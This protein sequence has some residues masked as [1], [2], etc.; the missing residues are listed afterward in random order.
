MGVVELV[1]CKSIGL[2]RLRIQ[3]T[4]FAILGLVINIGF[5]LDIA[6]V[7]VSATCIWSL[8]DLN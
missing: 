6:T 7:M 2:M 8:P 5:G 1:Q 3:K 4:K